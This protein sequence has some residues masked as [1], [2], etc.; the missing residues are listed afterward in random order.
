MTP[1]KR[2]VD[3]GRHAGVAGGFAYVGRCLPGA[4]RRA[5]RAFPGQG[6]W[7]LPRRQGGGLLGQGYSSAAMAGPP[8]PP[9]MPMR[10]TWG[11]AGSVEGNG[12]PPGGAAASQVAGRSG[13]SGLPRPPSFQ[14]CAPIAHS[15]RALSFLCRR[16]LNGGPGLRLGPTAGAVPTSGSATGHHAGVARTLEGRRLPGV[17]IATAGT[18]RFPTGISAS[19][20][21]TQGPVET[22][23]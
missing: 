2:T 20:G 12:C 9:C 13:R 19:T 17:M 1:C 14:G 7:W 11:A 4:S 21:L 10:R 18:V 3:C 5:P 22:S 23:G 8:S 16:V 15:K 6:G